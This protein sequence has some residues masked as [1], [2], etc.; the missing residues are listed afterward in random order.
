MEQI[1]NIRNE[2]K[3]IIDIIKIKRIVNILNNFDNK[4]NNLDEMDNFFQEHNKNTIY[5]NWNS[6]IETLKSS[7][8]QINWICS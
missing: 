6:E 5:H 3:N 1:I 4:F 8:S 2:S 7:I